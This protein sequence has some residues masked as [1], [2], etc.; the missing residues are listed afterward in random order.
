MV[1]AE[2][3]T[4]DNGKKISLLIVTFFWCWFER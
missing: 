2:V 3:V 4:R 1:V